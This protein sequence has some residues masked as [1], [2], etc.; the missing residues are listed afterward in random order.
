MD[1]KLTSKVAI[2]TGAA[3][4]IGAAIAR[5]FVQEGCFVYVTDINDELGKA[6]ANSLGDR[7]CYLRLDV[8]CEED[9]QR[10]ATQVMKDHG[11]WN[12]LVNNA[13]ITGFERGAVRHDPE[14]AR[15]ED[16]HDVH[17]TNLDGVF[18]G[19]KYAIR[20]MRHSGAGSI[21]NISSR[22]GLVGIPG[23]AAYASSKAAVRNHTKTVALY[24][25]EQGLKVRCNS[26]HPAAILTPIWEPM[27]GTDAGRDARM[28]DLVRDTPLRRFGMP[29][30]VAALALLLASDEAAYIT[31]SEFNIDG[32][33]LAGSAATPTVVEDSGT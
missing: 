31:G 32:G 20:A 7:A 28:A 4:G 27:L 22:S 8:R 18:L 17:R 3:Q 23:A 5:L 13:G 10:A 24:C 6:V 33:L 2:I 15:L 9:W 26:I 29:E 19:C 11:S 30:E 1:H 16:W 21:I 14:H 12:V 25:A